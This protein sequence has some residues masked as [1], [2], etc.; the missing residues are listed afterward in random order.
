MYL[1]GTFLNQS[2]DPIT[3]HILTHSDPTD[4]R[5]IGTPESG[6][7]FTDD[8]IDIESQ[9]TDTFDHILPSQA[10]IRLLVPN[11]IPQLFSSA[12]TDVIVN[13][14]QSD[15]LI[16]AGYVEPRAYSQP[17]NEQLDQLELSCI[18]HLTAIADIPYRHITTDAKHQAAL[19]TADQ[20]TFQQLITDIIATPRLDILHP[21]AQ[22]TIYYDGSKCIQEIDT[23]SDEQWHTFTY[24]TI[25]ELL[26]LGTERD[27]LSTQADILTA[28][29]QYLNLH[30]IQQGNT[31][32][33][34]S[35][36]TIRA[37]QPI[38]WHDIL[39]N[40]THTTQPRTIPITTPIVTDTDTEISL[41]DIHNHLTITCKT[42]PID[43][44]IESPLD[45]ELI[46]SPY[47][48]KQLILTEIKA[49]GT[50][51]PTLL[52]FDDIIHDRGWKDD[53]IWFTD[54]YAQL[55]TNGKWTF[56]AYKA[57]QTEQGLT[58]IGQETFINYLGNYTA[59]PWSK[60]ALISLGKI[61]TKYQDYK[62][63]KTKN[64]IDMEKLFIISVN[65]NESDE[66]SK[67][68][69]N[70][71]DLLNSAPV[72]TYSSSIAGG[73]MSPADSKTTNYLVISGKIILQPIM[74]VTDCY[75]QLQTYQTDKQF[76]FPY[77]KKPDNKP[78]YKWAYDRVPINKDN[79][80][81]YYTRKYYRTDEESN[82]IGA[83]RYDEII[84]AHKYL[85]FIPHND[86]SPQYYTFQYS[87]I[88]DSADTI[89][90]LGVIACMLIVGDK[91]LVEVGTT[92]TPDDYQWRYYKKRED[93]ATDD[94]YYQQSFTIGFD[95]DLGDNL[96]GKEYPIQNNITHPLGIEAEGTAIPIR[97]SDHL[98]G[99]VTFHILGAANLTYG[100]V[101]R[102]HPTWFRHTK[103]SSTSIPLMAHVQNIVIRD[104]EIKAYTDNALLTTYT[105][106]DIIYQSDTDETFLNPRDDIEFTITSALTSE[107]AFQL[108]TT[109]PISLSTPTDIHEGKPN[110]QALLTIYDVPK[111]TLVKPEQDYIDSYYTEYHTPHIL[112]TQSITDTTQATNPHANLISPFHHYTHPALGR[113][114][115]VQSINRNL[116]TATATL[117]LKEL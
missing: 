105:D 29:L 56:S 5:T 92:G 42:T 68:R 45:D 12:A 114:F 76:Q 22:P 36:E 104:F 27:D 65:G 75:Y 90:K 110:A 38:E 94:E 1:H 40:H 89:R 3:V 7:Y 99:R 115:H 51:D 78:I 23:L 95:P 8:P 62:D 88:G 81:G 85:G 87:A 9:V 18:D 10:T 17:Y 47:P 80:Y 109:T 30:I 55:L 107:E 70:T 82:K 39:T 15:T 26:F 32:Y 13:I 35:W 33:I 44:L 50:D 83:V 31:Y 102:R 49:R 48:N 46:S 67:A 117:T 86:D 52:A 93:C 53:R 73:I 21:T 20:L 25:N 64:K 113:T 100:Q 19:A 103:W 24:L 6:I 91:C 37:T 16:F 28:I 96:L 116:M 11:Y 54:W 108:G 69:P 58:D 2:T 14:Y 111:H 98:S 79:N 59:R 63:Q 106:N 77:D 74:K 66:E 34:Y 72:A 60:S 57:L 61:E 84:S 101:T 71:E 43:T 41:A 97:H 4:E 112:L